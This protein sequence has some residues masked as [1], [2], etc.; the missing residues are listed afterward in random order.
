MTKETLC[1]ARR[2]AVGSDAAKVLPF[3]AFTLALGILHE[4]NEELEQID[5]FCRVLPEVLRIRLEIYHQAKRWELMEV[6]AKQLSRY[7]RVSRS[8]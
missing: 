2:S 6:V 5:P 3:P 4:A 8:G 1:S 7:D